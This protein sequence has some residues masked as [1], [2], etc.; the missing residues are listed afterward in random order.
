MRV[1]GIGYRA[2]AG[3]VSLLAAIEAAGGL[4][5]VSAFATIAGKEGGALAAIARRLGLPVIAVCEHDL[6]AQR[7][8]T[9]SARIEALTGAGSVAEAAALYAAGPGARLFAPRSVSPDRMATAAIAVSGEE[10]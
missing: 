7:T 3:E 1:A 9:S 6:A 8:Q 5:G 2:S 4:E 10:A